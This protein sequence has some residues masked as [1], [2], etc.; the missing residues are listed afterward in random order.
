MDQ[1]IR[2]PEKEAKSSTDSSFIRPHVNKNIKH[3]S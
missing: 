2:R 1:Q 3:Q